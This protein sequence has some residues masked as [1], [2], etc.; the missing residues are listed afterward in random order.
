VSE[1]AQT[2][3][4]VRLLLV[5][6]SIVFAKGSNVIIYSVIDSSQMLAQLEDIKSRTKKSV[7]RSIRLIDES[8]LRFQATHR[9]LYAAQRSQELMKALP[10]TRSSEA[11]YRGISEDT[12]RT[13]EA[14]TALHA[15]INSSTKCDHCDN[16]IFNKAFR[17]Q[18]QHRGL[19]LLDMIVCYTCNLEAKNLGL[20]TEEV[21]NA[22]CQAEQIAANQVLLD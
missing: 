22:K 3:G 7:E 11:V 13:R 21:E 19:I 14:L 12:E 6:G 15:E 17:V 1:N 5:K 10:K 20:K 2:Y 16:I 9:N 4:R 18:T 8:F